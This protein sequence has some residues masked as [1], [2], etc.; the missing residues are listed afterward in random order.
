MSSTRI[1]IFCDIN[2]H[3]NHLVGFLFP[4]Y[5]AVRYHSSDSYLPDYLVRGTLEF[6]LNF[7]TFQAVEA[8]TLDKLA[9]CLTRPWTTSSERQGEDSEEEDGE[10]KFGATAVA[11]SADLLRS[12]GH[13]SLPEE[14]AELNAATERRDRALS[15]IVSNYASTSEAQAQDT[16]ADFQE[17]P[18]VAN[19]QGSESQA[20]N[21]RKRKRKG[22]SSAA[23]RPTKQ[24]AQPKT[25]ETV[26][27]DE[28]E[29]CSGC[30][31]TNKQT[32]KQTNTEILYVIEGEKN[33]NCL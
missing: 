21:R 8:D 14:P 17:T 16:E 7:L 13:R 9:S 26:T 3:A 25:P 6:G 19:P 4:S 23:S 12:I 24:K 10:E 29:T 20:A 18:P 2:G 33:R 32:S 28:G 1:F 30:F 27:T 11:L 31:Q 22:A 15:R 5:A